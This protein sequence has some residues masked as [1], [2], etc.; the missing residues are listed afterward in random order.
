MSEPAV[1][2]EFVPSGFFAW[3]TPL[4]PFDEILAWSDGLEAPTAGEDPE[5]REAACAADR[6]RL[7]SR[8]RAALTRP[9]VREA[10]FLASPG[11]EERLNPWLSGRADRDDPKM[12]RALVR[13]FARMAGRATPFG[14]FAGCSVGTVGAAT[15]LDLVA[16]AC[17]TRHTRLDMDYL[18]TLIDGLVRQPE[19][20]RGLRFDVNSSLYAVGDRF[21]Y[22]EVRRNGE[23]WTH[24]HVALEATDYLAATLERAR[25]DS[26]A[27]ALA[28]SLLEDDPGAASDEAEE[29]IGELI[30]NQVLVSEL[31][32]GVTGPEPIHD[33]VARLR[34]RSAA[35]IADRLERVRREL[36]AL[37][38]GGPGVEPSQYRRIAARLEELPGE[39]R[40]DRL[41][42]VDLVK[43]AMRARL[44]TAVL[45]EILRG[46]SLLHRLCR[47]PRDDRLARFREAFARRYEGREVPLVEALDEEAGVGFDGLDGEDRDASSLLDDL[48][49]PKGAE[50]PG[51][52]GRRE[53][54]LMRKLCEALACGATAIDIQPEDLKA[55][56]EPSP[57]PLPDSFAVMAAVAAASE[58]ALDRGEFQVRLDG[59][60][61]P[62]GAQLLGRFCHADPLLQEYVARLV[63]AEEALRPDAVFAEIVHLPEGRMGNILARPVLRDFEIPYLGGAAVPPR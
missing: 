60:S 23:G 20:R 45:D 37:D 5:R 25:E 29:Y 53:S 35:P 9:E 15:R 27:S 8:L 2:H 33:L 54:I 39:P 17:Y 1:Q 52:W 24:H 44:G 46:V 34:E 57:P 56:A 51:T 22:F 31:R 30:G 28:A 12:E 3:R 4:L 10:L 42:Q 32:P 13:Y 59:V 43:P 61:G 50:E 6:A 62:S 16:R 49:F 19:I 55:M 38:A 11:L 21:R 48:A 26:S 41:F 58:G 40:I 18:V 7:V 14:L 63:Q 47:R 36:E